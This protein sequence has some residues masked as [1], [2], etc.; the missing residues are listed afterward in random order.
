MN[1]VKGRQLQINSFSK[2]FEVFKN[3]EL[4][5]LFFAIIDLL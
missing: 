5:E 1:V 2:N 3:Y 4:Y